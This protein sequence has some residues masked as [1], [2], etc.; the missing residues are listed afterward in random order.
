MSSS[1]TLSL[2][3]IADEL[4][5]IYVKWDN[6]RSEWKKEKQELVSY[7]YATDTTKTSNSK[8][9]WSNK[10]TLP[11]LTSIME[12]LVSN[13]EAALFPNSDWLEWNSESQEASKKIKKNVITAYI[14]SKL[15]GGEF[16]KKVRQ[17]LYDWVIYGIC[18]SDI[19]YVVETRKDEDGGEFSVFTGAKA[20]RISPLDIVIDPTAPS[21]EES[22]KIRRILKSVGDLVKDVKDRPELEYDE[23]IVA[24]LK[25]DRDGFS[26]LSKRDQKEKENAFQ[27]DGFG[28]LSQYYTSGVV[29][30]LEFTGTVYDTDTGEVTENCVFTVVD[31]KYLLR[32][33][34]RDTW[35]G[36]DYIK[37]VSWRPR[38]DNLWGMGPL[39]NIVGMQYR[40]DH[41]ENLKADIMDL[42]AYPVFVQKGEVDFKGWYP[43]SV[44]NLDSE[45]SFDIVKLDS[46]ALEYNQDITILEAKME[47][48]AGAPREAM[49]IRSP[50]E[51]TAF[52]VQ[53]LQNASS[54]LFQSKIAYFEEAFLEPL[55][56]QILEVSRR[57]FAYAE[58]I[59]LVSDELGIEI[60][61]AIGKEDLQMSGTLYP[62]GARHFAAK[63]MFVQEVTQLMQNLPPDV[64]NHISGKVIARQLVEHLNLEKFNAYQPNIRIIEQMEQQSLMQSGQ[65]QLDKEQVASQDDVVDAAMGGM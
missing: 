17:F 56:N 57:N 26:G 1:L 45:S 16:R 15:R 13:Y 14:H 62:R 49:G 11:K 50:G 8:L 18:F 34:K 21:I 2:S 37:G 30:L 31:R 9:P 59:K 24:R 51:K 7:L 19:E 33:S 60:F 61:R 29:E 20:V 63:A 47:E 41:L 52:E 55:V 42:M 40:I 54:R 12:N 43:N 32:Q 22:P 36:K 28:S 39:D 48:Y 5:R 44:V 10:T 3:N 25:A 23:D 53:S 35:N 6:E 65:A 58:Q 27:M 64:T 38:P 46:K 4:S